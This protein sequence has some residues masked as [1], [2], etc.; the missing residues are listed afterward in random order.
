MHDDAL[1]G[2]EPYRKTV[3]EILA[4][5]GTDARTGLSRSKAQE[6]LGQYGKNELAAEAPVSA[7]RKFLGQFTD[8]LVLL[9]LVAALISAALWLYER[10]SALPYDAIAIFAIVLLNA[11]MGYFQ[12]S[13]AEQAVAALRQMSA[14]HT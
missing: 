3:D 11:L 6:R 14:M 9:L 13:R 4:K 8:V 7:W 10:D 5:L 2:K 12:Q 1:A